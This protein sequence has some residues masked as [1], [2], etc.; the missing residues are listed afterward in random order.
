MEILFLIFLTVRLLAFGYA[1]WQKDV[2][3]TPGQLNPG[4]E[5][6]LEIR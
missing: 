3:K 2:F 6:E 1:H 4:E 5:D